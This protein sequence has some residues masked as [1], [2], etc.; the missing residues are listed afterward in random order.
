MNVLLLV[1]CIERIYLIDLDM[2]DWEDVWII[3][4]MFLDEFIFVFVLE[5][6]IWFFLVRI[7]DIFFFFELSVWKNL[8]FDVNVFIDISKFFV[9][10]I[11]C[12][13][14]WLLVILVGLVI[15][16]IVLSFWFCCKLGGNVKGDW[17]F[18]LCVKLD[19]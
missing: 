1:V 11:S 16:L 3:W 4:V 7:D 14:V 2:C 5:Y 12:Y 9:N 13:D 10:L 17:L 15:L 18:C 6:E 8:L 19:R